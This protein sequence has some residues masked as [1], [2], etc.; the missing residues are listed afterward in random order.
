[1]VADDPR[2]YQSLL[3]IHRQR[4]EY[5]HWSKQIRHRNVRVWPVQRPIVRFEPVIPFEFAEFDSDGLTDIRQWARP[6][7]CVEKLHRQI[8]TE[9]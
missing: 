2:F 3:G 7:Y 9:N 1:M 5:P 8:R 6:T 4:V